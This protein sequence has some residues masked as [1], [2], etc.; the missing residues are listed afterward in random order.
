MIRNI[1]NKSARFLRVRLPF[2]FIALRFC[3]QAPF[4]V[5]AKFHRNIHVHCDRA[6]G[7]EGEHLFGYYDKSP[8]DATGE[9]L[10]SLHVPFADRH[11]L[12]CDE[13]S[14]E[15]THFATGEVKSIATTRAWNLQQGCRLQWL[16]P[17]FSSRIIYNDFRDGYFVSVVKEV[18]S[19]D[20]QVFERAV[21]DLSKD[22]TTALSLDFE[23][24]HLFRPGYGYDR[25]E[26]F[27]TPEMFPKDNGIWRTNLETGALSLIISLAQIAEDIGDPASR[28]SATRF[29]HI[30]INPSGDRFMFLYRWKKD[31]AESTRLYTANMDGSDLCC[32]AKDGLVSHATWK[33]DDELLAWAFQKDRGEHFYLI[34]DRSTETPEIVGKGVLTEDGHPSYSPCGRYILTD[35]YANRARQRR[36][37]VYDTQEDTACVI[38][39][40]YAPFRYGGE[41]RCDL[42]PRWKQDGKQIC[43]DSAYEGTRQVYILDKPLTVNDNETK[44]GAVDKKFQKKKVVILQRIS[45][46]YRV[47]FYEQLCASLREHGIELTVVY[48]Q[49]CKF[50]TADMPPPIGC[51]V[52]IRNRYIYIGRRFLVW[53]SALRHLR[54]ADLI[55]VQQ[56]TRN[57][58]NY[59]L[60]LFRKIFGYK[61]AYWG[62]GRNFQSNKDSWLERFKRF[63]SRH[64]DFC[65]AY[66][67]LSAE[68]VKNL[69][70]PQEKIVSVDNAIDTRDTKRIS[71][72]IGSGEIE[73][74][75]KKYGLRPEMPVGIFCSRLYCKKRLPFLIECLEE[76]RRKVPDFHFILIGDGAEA[77]IVHD[78]AERHGDWFHWVGARYGRKKICLFKL[79]QF[80]L[81]PGA[82]G[83]NIVESFALLTPIVT[84]DI[85]YH[86]P[87]IHYLDS[88]RN[89]L[90]TENSKEAY[91]QTVVNLIWDTALQSRLIEGCRKA[92]ERYTIENMVDRFS[93]GIYQSLWEKG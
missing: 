83:L 77:S 50:E 80:Q 93:K 61:L 43:I 16:G 69:G 72:T 90:M 41:T 9:R 60:A 24:L 71:D 70:Y 56:A 29:N 10:I 81:M 18:E 51:G 11:P 27:A 15:L 68:I 54:G 49:H 63:Y 74:A 1:V 6:P 57:L 91:V 40:F 20:E 35:T 21:C 39:A 25:G 26:H 64:V 87:E 14:I 42:H 86:G 55:I 82:V 46:A 36:L 3:Y 47:A 17:D 37:I 88:G 59:P 4:V 89:G 76:I 78:F 62:H 8:W 67:D 12:V 38:G 34:R 73:A 7:L 13:A 5:F 30:M 44:S 2:V 23:R 53:Q 22:G 19:G 65:F 32:L 33:N 45:A 79:A 52:V 84:T 58:I 31:E 85:S 28:I 92:R 48:G 75:R 66:N